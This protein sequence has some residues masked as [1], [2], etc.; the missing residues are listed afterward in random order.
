MGRFGGTKHT[1]THPGTALRCHA[2][3]DMTSDTRKRF[4]AQI[5]VIGFLEEFI[6]VAAVARTQVH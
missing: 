5:L 6:Q 1:Q 4:A 2:L 3:A